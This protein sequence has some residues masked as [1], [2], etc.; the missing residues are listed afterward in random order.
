MAINSQLVN[1]DWSYESDVLGF[2]FAIESNL[3]KLLN[4]D[5]L[6]ASITKAYKL[7]FATYAATQLMNPGE[8]PTE[9]LP[10]FSNSIFVFQL[11]YSYIPTAVGTLLEPFWVLLTRFICVLQ[12]FETL[13]G[14]NALA[15][16]SLVLKFE[17]VPP[18]LTLF[19]A[20]KSHHFL[21]SIL[22]ATALSTNILAIALGGLFSPITVTESDSAAVTDRYQHIFQAVPVVDNSGIINETQIPA[23]SFPVGSLDHYYIIYANDTSNTPLPA[24]T[25]NETFFLPV[26]QIDKQPL[27][28]TDLFQANTIGLSASLD[29]DKVDLSLNITGTY[30]DGGVMY[31]TAEVTAFEGSGPACEFSTVFETALLQNTN[32][33]SL[34]FN[35]SGILAMEAYSIP[36]AVSNNTS[37]ND[38]CSGLVGVVF[39]RSHT[40]P[41][42]QPFK[43]KDIVFDYKALMCRPKLSIDQY[44]VSVDSSSRIMKAEINTENSNNNDLGFFRGDVTETHLFSSI[45]QLFQPDG[46]F[47]SAVGVHLDLAFSPNSLP[48]EWID[49]MIQKISNSTAAF[50]PQTEIKDVNMTT[51]A[52]SL[53]AAYS[54]VFAVVLGLYN[55][56][57]FPT[58]TETSAPAQLLGSR[59]TQVTRVE[60]STV[61]FALAAGLLG[62]YVVI[63]IY[64]YLFRVSHLFQR[65]PTC[66]ASE[67]QLFH[68]SAMLDDVRGTEFFTSRQREAHLA[69][70]GR[71][72]GYGRF[73]G[74]DGSMAVG[75]EREPL[76][77][78][79]SDEEV[80]RHG[81]GRIG[82]GLER[83]GGWILKKFS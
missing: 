79:L 42:A 34:N 31:A 55:D 35:Y 61:M 46:L 49:L 44:T 2:M 39:A 80:R 69:R 67:I 17:S 62:W 65:L 77:D 78:H 51:I 68:N 21:L 75:I 40:V 14:G 54:E 33:A 20:L 10:A 28:T 37:D 3:D 76:L 72:Y 15:A 24:W 25:T 71:R 50:D 83:I 56:R 41:T 1:S 23:H 36:A 48:T 8:A 13:R 26:D 73:I 29:C 60:M 45:R 4:K 5:V 64:F 11:L 66:L 57:F 58:S 38:A 53:S 52:Q 63:A 47:Q 82:L 9:G 74:R 70:I 16:N 43:P 32:I 59:I 81:L 19:S 12:P 18:A 22:A 6:T 27:Q 30:T 7:L